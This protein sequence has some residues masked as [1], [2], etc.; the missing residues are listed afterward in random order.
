MKRKGWLPQGMCWCRDAA[1]VLVPGGKR[2]EALQLLETSDLFSSL[3]RRLVK[4]R[5][6]MDQERKRP[7][8]T[9]DNNKTTFLLYSPFSIGVHISVT[10]LNSWPT[11]H[12][13]MTTL[14][15]Y[16]LLFPSSFHHLWLHSFLLS[17]GHRWNKY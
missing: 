13:R 10:C 3:R 2:L 9:D 1:D 7:S 14:L 16:P 15:L 6:E 4:T 8:S 17:P 12:D 11:F 5:P